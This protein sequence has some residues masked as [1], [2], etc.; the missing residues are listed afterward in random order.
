MLR[1]ITKHKT[2][3][4]NKDKKKRGKFRYGKFMIYCEA[5]V[6]LYG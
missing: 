1:K 5:R 6:T 3:M 2:V 4:M